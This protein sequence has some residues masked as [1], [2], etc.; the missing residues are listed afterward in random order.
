MEGLNDA[1]CGGLAQGRPGRARNQ[2]QKPW[3]APATHSVGFPPA[4]PR[5]TERARGPFY[6]FLD[7]T[8]PMWGEGVKAIGLMKWGGWLTWGSGAITHYN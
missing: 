6:P 8:P 4:P 2:K 7:P 1:A 5:F 3:G